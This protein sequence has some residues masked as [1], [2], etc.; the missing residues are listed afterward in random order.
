VDADP[1]GVRASHWLSG[2]PF[3]ADDWW[4]PLLDGN[5]GIMNNRVNF[6][7]MLIF[8]GL[9]SS[10]LLQIAHAHPDQGDDSGQSS[11]ELNHDAKGESEHLINIPDDIQ[12]RKESPKRLLRPEILKRLRAGHC[13]LTQNT[14]NF[15]SSNEDTLGHC[16]SML[17]VLERSNLAATNRNLFKIESQYPERRFT[18]TQDDLKDGKNSR[19]LRQTITGLG[20]SQVYALNLQDLKLR[21]GD[22]SFLN[23]NCPNLQVLNLSNTGLTDIMLAQL[24]DLKLDSLD[25]SPTKD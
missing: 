11:P 20:P 10:L 5:G 2:S 22:M 15:S 4:G 24:Q 9:Y 19:N 16:L 6:I 21:S 14:G 12:D 3:L 7:R 1:D 25:L 8:F 13:D 23:Q 18:I 17:T